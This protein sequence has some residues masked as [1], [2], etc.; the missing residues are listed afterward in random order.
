MRSWGTYHVWSLVLFAAE[1]TIQRN[2]EV[3][4]LNGVVFAYTIVLIVVC[5]AAAILSLADFFVCLKRT[6]LARVGFFVF[7][8]L[9]LVS[10]FGSEWLV[11]N[12]PFDLSEYYA[13]DSPV[14][15]TLLSAGVL[16]CLWLMVTHILDEHDWRIQF[17]P[18]CVFMAGCAIVVLA[19]PV[20][21]VRQ[22]MFY[23]MRQVYLIFMLVYA[24]VRWH[25]SSDE[26]FRHRVEK[27]RRSFV[28][29]SVL[30]GCI[31]LE[32]TLVILVLPIPSQ[33]SWL[34]L[35]LASRNFSENAMMLYV[36]YLCIRKAVRQLQL[37]ATEA[38][39]AAA[40]TGE[41]RKQDLA[42]HIEDQLPAYASTHKL[43]ARER[44]VLG[45]VLE[46]KDNR[47]I[48]NE[49]FLSEGTVKTH[50]HNIMKKTETSSRDEL[51]TDFWRA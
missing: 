41:S 23:S 32:D 5:V 13:I 40:T 31:L 34:T 28:V 19:M 21:P 29:M 26:T 16:Q 33:S 47:T 24:Y 51:K 37:R 14:M 17:L 46:G 2:A 38:P 48:A 49:L 42:S 45:M 20:G 18:T 9:D 12:I 36:A 11:Q 25:A 44:E 4:Q 22:W 8:I 30:V 50:V 15:K 3:C 43:S 1:G 6:V 7:Y 10:I 39:T 27:Y 35:F